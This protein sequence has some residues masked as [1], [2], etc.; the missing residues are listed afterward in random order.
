MDAE[1]GSFF[2]AVELDRD[3]AHTVYFALLKLVD[4]LI[5]EFSV[6]AERRGGP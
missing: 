4:V 6:S 2:E 5:D 1:H 3:S